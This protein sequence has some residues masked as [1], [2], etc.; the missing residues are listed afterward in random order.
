[1]ISRHEKYLPVPLPA[2]NFISPEKAQSEANKFLEKMSKRHSIRDFSDTD[3]N[4]NVIRTVI[5]TA[6]RAP[7]GANQ[8][9]WHF[10][11]IK[12]TE[13]KQKIRDAAEAEEQAFYNGGGGDEWLAA[14]E[15]IGTGPNKP[16]LTTAPWLIIVF[17]QRYGLR[18]DGTRYKHYYVP[19]SV[20]IATGILITALHNCG[21]SLVTHTPNPMSFLNE[22]CQR[23]KN[24][25]PV[26]IIPVG[27]PT[28]KTTIPQASLYKKTENDILSVF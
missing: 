10:V 3:I 24:E 5:R 26:M 1:M 19:E 16:H 13:M 18:D 27:Y 15:S 21:L 11:A 9:P 17:A 4:E 25:K 22:V 7:S 28:P 2:H 23:P 6:A 8:Q 12:D 14:L 20:G